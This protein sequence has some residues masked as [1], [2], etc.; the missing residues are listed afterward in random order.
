MLFLLMVLE[1][2]G[3][4]DN[5]LRVWEKVDLMVC[6]SDCKHLHQGLL[7]AIHQLSE[8][9]WYENSDCEPC[10]HCQYWERL[11]Q[12]HSSQESIAPSSLKA[13]WIE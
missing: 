13:A 4:N 11:K 12:C 3:S 10:Y 8:S 2:Y 6:H 9:E 7:P 1:L 5:R